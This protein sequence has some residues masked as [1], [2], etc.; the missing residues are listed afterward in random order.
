MAVGEAHSASTIVNSLGIELCWRIVESTSDGVLVVE[1]AT[2]TILDCDE[3]SSTLTGYSADQ[4]IGQPMSVLHAKGQSRYFR[5]IFKRLASSDTERSVEL[6]LHRADGSEMWVEIT[7]TA[8]DINGWDLILAVYR[9]CSDRMRVLEANRR[10]ASHLTFLSRAALS[11]I[12]H[13]E[14][15]AVYKQIA[16]HLTEICPGA[17]TFVCSYVSSILGMRVEAYGNLEGWEGAAEALYEELPTGTLISPEEGV[18]ESLSGS[19]AVEIAAD[20]MPLTRYVLSRGAAKGLARRLGSE[21]VY[22]IGITLGTELL[23]FAGL[24]FRDGD[25]LKDRELL[26]TYA[27]QVP[28][29]VQRSLSEAAMRESEQLIRRTIDANPRPMFVVDTDMRLVLINDALRQLCQEDGFSPD[30]QGKNLF[31]A[32][33]FLGSGV[34]SRYLRVLQTRQASSTEEVMVINGQDRHV[35]VLR[36]PIFEADDVSLVMTM[37]HDVTEERRAAEELQLVQTQLRQAQKMEA[38]ASLAGGVAHDFNNML[39]VITGYCD[40]IQMELSVDDDLQ[41]DLEQIRAAAERA[42]ALTEQ[43]LAFSNKQII[44]PRVLSLDSAVRSFESMLRPVIDEGVTFELAL[45]SQP[46]LVHVDPGQLEQVILNL[47]I[48]ARDAMPG[49][50]KLRIETARV[51]LD[52][53]EAK[54]LAMDGPATYLRLTVSD[55]GIGMDEETRQRIFEPFFTTKDADK[56]TG[57]G[58]STVYGIISQSNGAIDVESAPWAGTSFHIYLPTADPRESGDGSEDTQFDL[59]PPGTE[60]ILVVEDEEAMLRVIVRLLEGAGYK[61]LTATTGRDA[62]DV[63]RDLDGTLHLLITDVVM[64]QMNGRELYGHLEQVRPDTRVL[65]MSGYTDDYGL[66]S[67]VAS[68][69]APFI[70]KPFNVDQLLHKVRLVLNEEKA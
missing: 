26:E 56:G 32:F 50:G 47:V 6:E 53:R 15:A 45:N 7:T 30:V 55:E 68:S 18:I 60:T 48:N 11:L 38:I 69:D 44:D 52:L 14:P 4:L 3:G 21:R 59:L 12:A 25:D 22:L 70:Q 57:L 31:E 49:G 27:S 19:K 5:R 16:Q 28:M 63:A 33:P 23:G 39:G 8:F 66:R 17:L 34:R 51:K 54:R 46:G 42:R 64:P 9:D 43:L 24:L 1:A 37:L 62:L 36:V 58:L 67:D 65:F 41:P 10:A 13:R 40:C 35:E 20:L 29:A 61:V 2:D